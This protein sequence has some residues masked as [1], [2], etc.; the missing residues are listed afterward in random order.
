MRI[1]IVVLATLAALAP[2]GAAQLT[3]QQADSQLRAAAKQARKDHA[4]S[5]KLRLAA[6][7][8]DVDA[9][10]A[11]NQDGSVGTSFTELFEDVV[12]FQVDLYYDFIGF[13]GGAVDSAIALLDQ[14]A[15]GA[16]LDGAYPD[17][18]RFGTGRA[19]DDLRTALQST[20]AKTLA[21]A[22][23]L[24][25][26][27]AGKLAKLGNARL[28]FLLEPATIDGRDGF[29]QGSTTG[30]TRDPLVLHTVLALGFEGLSGGG[31]I[32]VAGHGDEG[33]DA[34]SVRAVA[35][36]GLQTATPTFPEPGSPYWTALLDAGG[37]GLPDGNAYVVAYQ[38]AYAASQGGSVSLP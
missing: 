10:L 4:A 7:D 38:G 34:I 36:G 28:T 37:D 15:D 9:F 5:L 26:K 19:L 12:R 33:G 20:Q 27:A 31:V 6:L 32:L 25:E 16:D 22:R 24:L 18:F 35:E 23:K 29:I 1:P 11:A 13:H 8:A 14:F 3:E 17:E 21:K 2:A 30:Q